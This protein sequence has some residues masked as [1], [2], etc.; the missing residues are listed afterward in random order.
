MECS[1]YLRNIRDKLADRHSPYEK[2]NWDFICWSSNMEQQILS[3]HPSQKTK[4]LLHQFGKKMFPA[5]FIGY[6][7]ISGE[8]WTGD[9]IIADWHDIE[10]N[11]ASEVHVARLK[12]K[13]VEEQDAFIFSCADVSL[14]QEGHAQRETLRHQ[15]VESFD[16]GVP[17]TFGR[18]EE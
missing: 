15:S 11:V 7:L 3:I 14:K 12:S 16:A 4:G 17:S 5:I 13:E 10:N 9:W 8:G 6:A 18:G 1:S 2:K